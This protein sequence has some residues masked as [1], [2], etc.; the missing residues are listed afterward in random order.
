MVNATQRR[1]LNIAEIS[2]VHVGN[3]RTPTSN[4]LEILEAAF[5][6]NAKTGE[7]DIIFIAGDFFDKALPLATSVV[8]DIHSWISR[9]IKMCAK[10]DIVLRVLEGTPSHDRGQPVIFDWIAATADT[11]ADVKYFS[12]LQIEHITRFGIDI[13]Y[14]QDELTSSC[15]T[16]QELVTNALLEKGLSKVDYTIM[17]GMF[18][19]RIPKGV[20]AD[21]HDASF[22]QHIT[23]KYVFCGHIHINA[24]YGNILEAGST[25][26]ISFN[27]EEDKGHWR[28]YESKTKDKVIHVKHPLAW[29]YK[30]LDVSGLSYS[31]CTAKV[32]STIRGLRD[33]SFLQLFGDRNDDGLRS[34]KLIEEE[35]PNINFKTKDAELS[36]KMKVTVEDIKLTTIDVVEISP[37]N[38]LNEV[39]AYARDKS[40]MSV[41]QQ[42]R[43]IRLLGQL[44]GCT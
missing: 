30:R 42:E 5:P 23:R 10:W 9:F 3:R 27:E 11:G 34:I 28:V 4:T 8:G 43:C 22:Y 41:A 19:H 40:S 21:S 35:F 24:R 7:L 25:D 13:L 31:Q 36:D 14:I 29:V 15:A 16:T 32:K 26:R 44:E 33:G 18:S 20:I 17:H 1:L 38:L 39:G 12:G 2:D 6:D 37:A